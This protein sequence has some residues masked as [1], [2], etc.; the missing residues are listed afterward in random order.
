MLTCCRQLKLN[1]NQQETILRHLVTVI[2][3]YGP[4][5]FEEAK[6]EAGCQFNSGLYLCTGQL[7]RQRG[8]PKIQYI[9]I[10]SILGTRVTERHHKLND[11]TRQRKIWLGEVTSLGSP[12]KKTKKTSPS[13]DFAEWALIYFLKPALNEKKHKTPPKR[14]ITVLSRWWKKDYETPYSNH[15]QAEWPD[16]IDYWPIL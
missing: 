3:W 4:Y 6:K 15:P 9:G 1:I 11:V 13:L 8:K 5:D 7:P 14:N 16:L 2:D 10:A 12:G